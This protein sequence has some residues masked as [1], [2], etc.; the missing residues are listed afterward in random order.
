MNGTNDNCLLSGWVKKGAG[1]ER[2]Y[3]KSRLLE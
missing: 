3:A 2:F 1:G